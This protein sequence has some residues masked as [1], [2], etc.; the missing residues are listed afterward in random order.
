MPTGI[1]LQIE[2]LDGDTNEIGANL[3]VFG[4]CCHGLGLFTVSALPRT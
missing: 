1:I 3:E 4:Q 2:V